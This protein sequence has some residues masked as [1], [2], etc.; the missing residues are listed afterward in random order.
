MRRPWG[1]HPIDETNLFRSLFSGH[2]TEY[3][4]AKKDAMNTKNKSYALKYAVKNGAAIK[5]VSL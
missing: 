5:T 3:Q 1:V 4:T 2:S